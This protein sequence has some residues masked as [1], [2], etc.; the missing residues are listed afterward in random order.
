MGKTKID[1]IAGVGIIYRASDPTQIFADFRSD[2]YPVKIFRKNLYPAGGNWIGEAARNDKNTKD[3]FIREMREELSL[4]GDQASTEELRLLQVVRRSTFY[5]VP[6]CPTTPTP[7]HI[8]T[9]ERLKK[10]MTTR[11]L[12][13]GD[14]RVTI[15]K[16]VLD[17]GDPENNYPGSVA[18]SSYWQVGLGEYEWQT[19]L[20]LQ[21]EFCNLSN[22]SLTTIVSLREI[23]KSGIKIGGGHDQALRDFFVIKGAITGKEISA[24]PGITSEYVGVPLPS[25]E[26]YLRCYDVLKNPRQE[27]C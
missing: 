15:P 13:F 26:D 24:I 5:N 8:Q 18:L 25:Y 7:T 21:T 2:S 9:L 23:L 4:E 16:E 17:R 10:A 14:Y 3:T 19:L 11:V 6:R 1:H 12:P 27:T 22:E 20:R